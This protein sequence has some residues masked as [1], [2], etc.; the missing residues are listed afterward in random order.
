MQY[1]PGNQTIT[2]KPAKTGNY[3]IVISATDGHLSSNMS[4]NISVVEVMPPPPTEIELIINEPKPGQR[5]SGTVP[6][7]GSAKIEDRILT[8]VVFKIDDGEWQD[9]SMGRMMWAGTVDTSEIDAGPHVIIVRA[10]DENGEYAQ[11]TVSIEVKKK[12]KPAPFWIDL[13]QMTSPPC[14]VFMIFVVMVIIS[15]VYVVARSKKRP[16]TKKKTPGKKVKERKA[17]KKK[18][19]AATGKKEKPLVSMESAFLVYHDGRLITY[20]SRGEIED[21]DAT[22]QVIKEFVRTSFRG[23][24]GRLD[25]LKY[26][27]MNVLL[28]RGVQ[29]YLVII[30]T[31]T[32]MDELRRVMRRFLSDVHERYKH[33][34][35][36]WDGKYKKVKGIAAMVESLVG[37][38]WGPGEAAKMDIAEKD[39]EEEEETAGRWDDSDDLG[40]G[41]LSKVEKLKLLEDKLSHGEIDEEEYEKLKK[42][43]L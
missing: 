4:F 33:I 36:T 39:E 16:A 22:L 2:W 43:Y 18:K 8:K 35:K 19:S 29:M 9:A 26:E 13:S 14:L 3:T 42:K 31:E 6:V 32:E 24:V 10:Y 21:L 12:L 34:L 11:E 27:N 25:Y 17:K 7:S 28:E 40:S 41:D 23:G 37:G 30:T 38:K 20:S 1:D 15:A 5:V